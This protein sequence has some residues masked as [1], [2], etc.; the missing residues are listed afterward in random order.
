MASFLSESAI[1]YFVDHVFL[2]PKLPHRDDSHPQIEDALLQHVARQLQ[3][4]RD[5]VTS[6]VTGDMEPVLTMF[7]YLLGVHDAEG[8]AI[9]EGKLREALKTL[10]R[11]G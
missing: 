8:L 6:Y 3:V 7:K 4:F 2:P 10:S 1:Q 11:Q 5:T 9:N